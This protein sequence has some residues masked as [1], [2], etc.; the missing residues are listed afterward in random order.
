MTFMKG[1]PG[2]CCCKHFYTGSQAISMKLLNTKL[3]FDRHEEHPDDATF[4]VRAWCLDHYHNRLFV[5]GYNHGT[6]KL[7]TIAWC[8]ANLPI[9]RNDTVMH[10]LLT[11]G[12]S[13]NT[14]LMRICT[15]SEAEKIYYCVNDV[16]ATTT[17]HFYE[18]GFDGTGN[19]EVFS[20]TMS[21]ASGSLVRRLEH[22]R[23]NDKLY[24]AATK[25]GDSVVKIYR[26]D[27]DGSNDQLVYDP[28]SVS[29]NRST[30]FAF[31]NVRGK[32]YVA[33]QY[34]ASSPYHGDIVRMEL[35]GSSPTIVYDTG[36]Y[37]S[38]HLFYAVQAVRFSH[39]DDRLLWIEGSS[40]VAATPDNANEPTAGLWTAAP[41]GSDPELIVG[42]YQLDLSGPTAANASDI[43]FGCGYERLGS[44]T[45]A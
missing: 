8:K 5:L 20:R 7:Q 40:S 15:A 31:D 14:G 24:Y 19:V 11:V 36:N 34:L 12:S 13:F 10:D 28:G 22:C 38:P 1:A 37:V 43:D 2:C 17:Y 25:S 18:L 9:V 39:K 45:E 35:D 3:V 27:R 44:G 33:R 26:C 32:L 30:C 29:I 4:T 16:P 23:H 21:S 42:H 41:D 6:N